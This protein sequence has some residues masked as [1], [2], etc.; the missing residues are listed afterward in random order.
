MKSLRLNNRT[1]DA[2]L[3]LVR[4]HMF[5]L[6]GRAKPK[7]I[8]RRAV[9]LG[10]ETFERLIEIR[11]ADVIGSGWPVARVASA[12]NWQRELDRML[13]EGVP[14][15]VAELDVTGRD[16]SEWLGI[17]PS[18]MVGEIL[19]ALHKECVMNPGRNSR[20]ALKKSALALGK[21]LLL[22]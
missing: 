17:P 14:W 4:Y 7:T 20:E 2:V 11:R 6:E 10:R 16:I 21:R 22:N 1:R 13:A 15:T 19:K 8:R 18:P 12:D 5:D 3:P 9:M